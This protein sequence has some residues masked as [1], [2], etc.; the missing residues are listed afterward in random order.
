MVPA[1]EDI[2]KV[3]NLTGGYNLCVKASKGCASACLRFAGNSGMPVAQRAQ[4]VRTAFLLAHPHECGLIIGAELLAAL[5]NNPA[6]NLRL[7]TTSD[8]R[9]ELIAPDMINVLTAAGV[10]L[11][12]Y[13]A[14]A[15]ADRAPSPAYHLTYS[16]KEPAHTSDEYLRDILTAGGNVAVPFTTK[17]DEPLPA[18][19]LGFP[20]IDGDKSDERRNDPAGPN[21]TGVIVGLRAKGHLWRR[22]GGNDAGF[23]RPAVPASSGNA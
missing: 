17:R 19:F 20:V 15:P 5:R 13:T 18:T 11:Y 4:I 7:N 12:D 14:Y 22:P 9:W 3:F 6:I 21:G 1:A 16:A 2:R 10:N 23:I 8:I